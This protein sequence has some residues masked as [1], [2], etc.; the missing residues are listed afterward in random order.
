MCE[1]IEPLASMAGIDGAV[2]EKPPEKPAEKPA[3]ILLASILLDV[4][5]NSG[6][7]HQLQQPF[8][9]L[10]GVQAAMADIVRPVS[11]VIDTCEIEPP[12]RELFK[13]GRDQTGADQID[14]IVAGTRGLSQFA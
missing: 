1:L 11:P 5:R 9:T 3:S 8:A 7:Q 13:F 14:T 2:A 12:A 6:Q 4:L 10:P